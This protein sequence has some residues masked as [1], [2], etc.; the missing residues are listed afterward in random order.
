MKHSLTKAKEHSPDSPPTFYMTS[1]L[2][3]II[4]AN[5]PFPGMGWSWSI[6][7]IPVHVYCKDL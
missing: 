6:S 4:C 2:L 7:D 5:N 3:D 1:Y